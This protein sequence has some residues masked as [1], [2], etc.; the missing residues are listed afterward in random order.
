MRGGKDKGP[1]MLAMRGR[2]PTTVLDLTIATVGEPPIQHLDIYYALF[3]TFGFDLQTTG[4][5]LVGSRS[6][7]A[8][9]AEREPG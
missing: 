9:Q 2:S 1:R 3:R 5:L 4:I 7:G 8:G 6:P